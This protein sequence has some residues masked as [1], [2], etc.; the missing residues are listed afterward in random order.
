[1]NFSEILP[2]ETY[3]NYIQ[4]FFPLTQIIPTNHTYSLYLNSTW[5]PM[6]S[7]NCFSPKDLDCE[8]KLQF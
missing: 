3:G 2:I 1:M 6:S 8:N 7:S 4:S 5:F